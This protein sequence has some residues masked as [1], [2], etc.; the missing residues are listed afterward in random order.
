MAA[1]D[2][3]TATAAGQT[4]EADTG[5]IYVYVGTPPN[6]FWSANST[7]TGQAA[8]DARYVQ[9][10]GDTMTGNLV[11]NARILIGTTAEG[12]AKADNLTVADSGDS[13]ITI[14]SGDSNEGSLFFSDASTGTGE[15]A[16]YVKYDHANNNLTFGTSNFDQLQIDSSG[17]VGIGTASTSTGKL[18]IIN[19]SALNELEFKGNDYTNIYSETTSG[20]DIGINST[21]S[22]YLRFLTNNTERVRIDSSGRLLVGT[23]TPGATAG[24]QLTIEGSA[25][26]G[27]TI[28]SSASSAGSILFEDTAS[29]RGE[30]QY[31]HNDDYMR[32]KTAGNERMRIDSS[33]RLLLNG[34][35]DVRMEFGTTG[36][37]GTNNR[38]H[39]RGDGSSLKYNT[40]SGGLHIFEQ[41]GSEAMRIDSSGRVGIGVAPSTFNGNGDNLV[42]SS[43]GATGITID[44]TSSTNSSIH[45]ADG[46]TGSEAYRGYLVYS[47]SS[48]A[49]LFGT[50]G[51]EKMRIDSSG[52]VGIGNINPSHRLSIAGTANNVNSEIT[53]TATSVASAYIGA[54]ANGLNL[55]TDTAGIVFKTGVTGGGS[56]GGT[57]SEQMRIDSSGNVGIGE[58]SPA[59]G[60]DIKVDTN[61]VLVIDRGSANTANFNLQYN[62]TVTGQLSAANGDFQISASGASTPISFYANGSERMRIDSSGQLLIG[63]TSAADACKI[64]MALST[65]TGTYIETGGTNRH[66]NGLNKWLV[67]RHGY[68]GGS[69]EV[70]SIGVL[71]TSSTGGSGHGYGNIVFHTGESGNG[72]SGSTST[73]RMR[74]TAGGEVT[75]KTSGTIGSIT[76]NGW[77]LGSQAASGGYILIKRDSGTSLLVNRGVNDGEL[78]ALYGQ[79]TKEGS[80]SVSGSTVS[81]NGGHLTRW[82]QLPGNAIRVAIYRGTVLSNIDE[83]CEW[84]EENNEQLNRMKISD[85]EGDRNVSGVFQNWDEDDEE[86]TDDF[87]CAMTGD[88]V[89]RIGKD[90]TV[91]RGDLLMSAGDGTAKPQEDD[92]I[93]SKTIAKVTSTHVSETYND[94]SYCVPCVLMAC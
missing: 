60:L 53:I 39:I 35:T 4:F 69:K 92:I 36:T 74:V 76:T 31:S 66:N 86:Y 56:V 46:P 18:A 11:N 41:N 3:P 37:T 32:F 20:F 2:F 83:M 24:E 57:G 43:S 8:L 14:R 6:G 30:I 7:V 51:T 63:E 73:E 44:A 23:T 55:G 10:A 38:N 50:S 45:F 52:R 81:F 80:I 47:H 27:M 90:V 25:N 85:I 77:T 12:A 13:G 17:N 71:T 34:G 78:I 42:I 58:S 68:W 28:R 64:G 62:G 61:P 21:S 88:F 16:G 94:G 59:A 89:I 79:N 87:Y 19:T 54:N 40:C 5:V 1:L 9:V 91:E 72:D 70:A 49:M 15:Y 82:S 26:A 29:D 48:D 67:F 75:N 84:A 65:G 22:A 33:G 93:R